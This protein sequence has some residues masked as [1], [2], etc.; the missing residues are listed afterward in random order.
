APTIASEPL[1]VVQIFRAAGDG[2]PLALLE[3]GPGVWQ[4]DVIEDTGFLIDARMPSDERP[5]VA[6][7]FDR[8]YHPEIAVF[9]AQRAEL[10]RLAAAGGGEVLE[11]AS[12]IVEA[13]EDE[14][15][16]R[17]LRMPLLAAALA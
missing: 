12:A 15:V 17:S 6:I 9:G 10:S 7:G 1:P 16:I 3:R 5:T 2:E 13:V 14:S 8:P 11:R 4:A